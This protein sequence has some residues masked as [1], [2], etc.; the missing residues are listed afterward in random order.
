LKTPGIVYS[1]DKGAGSFTSCQVSFDPV[2]GPVPP[3]STQHQHLLFFHPPS[4]TDSTGHFYFAETGHYHFA[5]TP[6]HKN[7]V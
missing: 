2:K 3:F 6:K 7:L 4:L 1:G 5:A